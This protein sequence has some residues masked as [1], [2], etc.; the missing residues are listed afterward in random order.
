MTSVSSA[1]QCWISQERRRPF[2][3]YSFYCLSYNHKE[4]RTRPQNNIRYYPLMAYS[5][6]THQ[7]L[8]ILVFAWNISIGASIYLA[9]LRTPVQCCGELLTAP[10]RWFLAHLTMISPDVK[11]TQGVI[12]STIVPVQVFNYPSIYG[13]NNCQ[14]DWGPQ[15]V[16]CQW[17]DNDG[18]ISLMIFHPKL[19]LLQSILSK[20]ELWIYAMK[21]VLLRHVQYL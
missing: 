4:H 15:L 9:L 11:V 6:S 5:S 17:L 2:Q 19:M 14:H 16:C 18:T 12:Q 20:K 13:R 3:Y 8:Y 10:R 7:N 21:T 1:E